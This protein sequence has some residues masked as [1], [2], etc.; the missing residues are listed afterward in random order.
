[1]VGCEE[2]V[3]QDQRRSRE[4]GKEKGRESKWKTSENEQTGLQKFKGRREGL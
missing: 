4:E 1:V 2:N 3:A